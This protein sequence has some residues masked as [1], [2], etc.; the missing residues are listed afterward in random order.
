M[1][2]FNKS[3]NKNFYYKFRLIHKNCNNKCPITTT[4]THN[5]KVD[6]ESTNLVQR[7][8]TIALVLGV[9]STQ[10]VINYVH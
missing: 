10:C 1:Q 3:V 7:T 2:N 6:I 4:K 5:Y 8:L 9:H